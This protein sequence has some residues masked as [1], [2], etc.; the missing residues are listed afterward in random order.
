M[1]H[2]GVSLYFAHNQDNALTF[3]YEYMQI[4]TW[5]KWFNIF[6]T[7]VLVLQQKKNSDKKKTCKKALTYSVQTKV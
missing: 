3:L 1:K 7:K 6:R 5:I 4:V 2:N